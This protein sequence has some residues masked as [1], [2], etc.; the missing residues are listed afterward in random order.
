[1]VATRWRPTVWGWVITST[2]FHR[3]QFSH[4]HG[5]GHLA[6]THRPKGTTV[7]VPHSHRGP[8]GPFLSLA[9]GR[10]SHH[11]NIHF[12]QIAARTTPAS[13]TKPRW[14][15]RDRAAG[16]ARGKPAE[17]TET[18]TRRPGEPQRSTPLDPS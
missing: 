14:R 5:P 15:R 3:Q 9:G 4:N 7:R 6:H 11:N 12:M 8:F 16:R 13:T 17:R 2:A 10:A 18:D 1:M